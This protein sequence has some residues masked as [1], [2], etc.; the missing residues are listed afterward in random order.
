MVNTSD[1]WQSGWEAG[2]ARAVA[3]M[4]AR[5]TPAAPRPPARYRHAQAVP[6]EPQPQGGDTLNNIEEAQHKLGGL[7]RTRIFHLLN[8][9]NCG[10]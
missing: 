1:A 9:G 6:I 3:D 10:P 5:N 7:G 4:A 2:Y 8:T